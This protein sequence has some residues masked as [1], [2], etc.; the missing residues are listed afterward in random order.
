MGHINKTML[1]ELAEE[2]KS[3]K[4]VYRAVATQPTEKTLDLVQLIKGV[5]LFTF[6]NDEQLNTVASILSERH[7]DDGVY[8]CR[9]GD[10]GDE[11]FYRH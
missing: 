6:M 11:M 4:R 10:T 5:R 9:Q 8:L 7:E 3:V 1:N 2:L